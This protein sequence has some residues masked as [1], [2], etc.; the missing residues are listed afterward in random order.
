VKQPSTS[1]RRRG[2]TLSEMLV[3]LGLLV[4]VTAVAQPVLSGALSDSRLRSAAKLVRVELA[5]ARLRA[6]QTGIAQQFRYEVGKSHFEVAA[7]TP[8]GLR[9]EAGTDFGGRRDRTINDDQDAG[10]GEEVIAMSLPAGVAFDDQD[11]EMPSATEATQSGW[12]KPIVFYPDGQTHSARLRLKGERN[13]YVE[14]LLRGLTGVATAG[15][16]RHEEELR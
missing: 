7:A 9:G 13:S 1:T 14:I 11:D 12:S 3:V 5:K 15:R 10:P 4:T 2:F 16:L 6:M 8:E